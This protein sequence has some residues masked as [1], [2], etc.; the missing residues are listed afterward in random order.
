MEHSNAIAR[1]DVYSHHF[2]IYRFDG[3]FQDKLRDYCRTIAEYGLI[4]LP[5]G[6]FVRGMKK[7][8]VGVDKDRTVFRIHINLLDDFLTFMSNRGINEKRFTIIR[9]RLYSAHFADLKYVDD[10]APRDYQA[11]IIDYIVDPGKT[12][13]VT[14]D[15]GRGKTF[16]ALR[17]IH[18]LRVRAFFCIK[19]MYLEKWVGDAK[20][21]FDF[22]KGELLV[23]RGADALKSLMNMAGTE[24]YNGKIILCS[25]TTFLLYLKQY[26]LYKSNVKDLG[27]R[28]LPHELLEALDIGLRVIDE[29]HQD[30]HLNFRQDLYSHVPKTLSLSGTLITK[31]PFT[32]RMYDVMF[33]PEERCHI[34]HRVVYLRVSAFL[35]RIRDADNRVKYTNHQ[36]KAY[37]HMRFEKSIRRDKKLLKPYLEMIME[38][39]RTK[40]IENR[41]DGQKALI[42]FT[43]VEMCTKMTDLLKEN[44]SHLKISRYTQEDDYSEMLE[45]DLIVSTL[46]S[47]GTAH[48]IP[49]LVLAVMTDAL[50]SVQGNLQASGRLREVKDWDIT[51]E[52]IYLVCT[53]INKHMIYHESKKELF[54][55]RVLSHDNIFSGYTL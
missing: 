18:L 8:Y 29:V 50:D 28:Y 40:F 51:P 4:R 27:Y 48:D 14:L 43:T 30:F 42:Y 9:K 47:L 10:R 13:V 20:Q 26:E 52:F 54:A 15:P 11:P 2:C 21:A 55:G 31:D 46:K 36:L 3:Y 44:F 39:V 17:A 25:N 53:D 35:Y 19:A 6:K 5:T 33:P 12:K 45:S 24:E 32:R 41:E 22:K 1:I 38:L 23:I 34:V 7:V 16:I 37:S 49:G